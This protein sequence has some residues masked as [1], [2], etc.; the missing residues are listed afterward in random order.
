MRQ[1]R[2]GVLLRIFM[3]DSDRHEGKP[4]Y[5]VLVDRA[6][7]QG[8]AGATALHGPMGFGHHSRV[9]TSKLAELSAYLPIVIEIIDSR[10]AIE[11][12]MADIEAVVTE[13]LV[14]LENVRIVTFS[15]D[16]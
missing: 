8:L 15:V 2:E 7:A 10:E 13:G 6:R 4:L 11:R 9:H 1:E 16:R 3:G 5:H 12:F 14:T